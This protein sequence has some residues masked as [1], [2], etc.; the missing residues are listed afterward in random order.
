MPFQHARSNTATANDGK[1]KGEW[2]KSSLSVKVKRIG[3]GMWVDCCFGGASRSCGRWNFGE[4]LDFGEGR[5]MT[6]GFLEVSLPFNINL[7]A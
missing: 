3:R 6:K 7:S 1:R 5:K 2:G 4:F